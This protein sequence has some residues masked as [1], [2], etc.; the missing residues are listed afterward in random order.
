MAG[1]LGIT[2]KSAWFLAP[3]IRMTWLKSHDGEDSDMGGKES[4][5]RAVR[6]LHIGCGAVGKTAVVGMRDEAG[7]GSRYRI[8]MG[9]ELRCLLAGEWR[10]LGH[11]LD[12]SLFQ[13]VPQV[14]SIKALCPQDKPL[15]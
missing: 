2:Q 14:C 1:D 10:Q 5:K 13:Q 8:A 12:I 15:I 11:P 9:D 7:D 4:N 3:R 6:K